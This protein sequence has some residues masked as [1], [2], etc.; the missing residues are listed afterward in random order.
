MDNPRESAGD[1]LSSESRSLQPGPLTDARELRERAAQARDTARR[2]AA[3]YT[4][5]CTIVTSHI[6]HSQARREAAQLAQEAVHEAVDRYALLLKA[7]GTPPEGTL[8][9]VKEAVRENIPPALEHCQEQPF[10]EQVVV[11]CIE[12]YYRSTPAA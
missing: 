3:R 11:W 5:L 12:S 4:E 2:A 9:L 10:M 1:G 8:R 6:A 7:L